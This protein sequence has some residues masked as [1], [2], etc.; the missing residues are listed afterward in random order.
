MERSMNRGIQ[1]AHIPACNDFSKQVSSWEFSQHAPVHEPKLPWQLQ[2]ASQQ[3]AMAANAPCAGQPAVADASSFAAAAPCCPPSKPEASTPPFQQASRI[4]A[5]PLESA[6]AAAPTSF[7]PAATTIPALVATMVI[8]STAQGSRGTSSASLSSDAE[9]EQ[10]RA[11]ETLTGCSSA[12][13][14]LHEWGACKPCAFFWSPQGCWKGQ[15]CYHCHLC[16]QGEIRRR[17]REAAKHTQQCR[18]QSPGTRS[19][20]IETMSTQRPGLVAPASESIIGRPGSESCEPS[21][22][23]S[24][25]VAAASPTPLETLQQVSAARRVHWAEE[26]TDNVN[27]LAQAPEVPSVELMHFNIQSRLDRAHHLQTLESEEREP[28]E[29]WRGQL[30]FSAI[31]FLGESIMDAVLESSEALVAE[32]E[33]SGHVF[34]CTLTDF[35][36]DCSLAPVTTLQGPGFSRLAGLS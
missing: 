34:F 32:T 29:A 16:P 28:Q 35:L 3:S 2:Q 21:R 36:V 10:K 12:G 1:D 22:S 27:P 31:T 18:F 4:A 9:T 17:K 8:S 6:S 14:A 33:S 25:Q 19:L 20:P 23:F 7:I 26:L 13:S 15:E 11:R 5:T 30:L 24:G